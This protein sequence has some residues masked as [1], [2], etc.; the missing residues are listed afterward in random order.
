MPLYEYKYM[1]PAGG[2]FEDYASIHSD[3]LVTHKG[4][5]C[6]RTVQQPK[7]RTQYGAG[8]QTD[9]VEMFSIAVDNDDE[10]DAFRQRNPG[11]EISKKRG[12][13]LYGVPVAAS[14]SQKLQVLKHEGFAEK[15]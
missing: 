6:R 12:D 7:V 3:S 10:I 14:R 1:D 4:R 8:S 15:T 13:R 9:P 2:I 5:P 11:V